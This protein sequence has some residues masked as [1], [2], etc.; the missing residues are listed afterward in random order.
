[1]VGDV[2][3]VKY[4]ALEDLEPYSFWNMLTYRGNDN[5]YKKALKLL[6]R[7]NSFEDKEIRKSHLQDFLK[8][9]RKLFNSRTMSESVNQDVR[10]VVKNF[11]S[12]ACHAAGIEI[13]ESV[14][15]WKEYIDK[16]QE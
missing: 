2:I 11:F 3:K 12:R 13:D 16:Y 5:M 6:N 1:M 10:T 15:M 4:T 7:L 8:S 14:N 9:Y